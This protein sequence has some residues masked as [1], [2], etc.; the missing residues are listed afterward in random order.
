[1]DTIADRIAQAQRN[2]DQAAA[3]FANADRF[4]PDKDRLAR[5]WVRATD[6]LRNLK[7]NTV[8]AR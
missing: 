3:D 7:N 5:A 4:D 1:M 2:A 6:D 8:P